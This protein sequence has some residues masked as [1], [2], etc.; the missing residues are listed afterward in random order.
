M[1]RITICPPQLRRRRP[2]PMFPRWGSLEYADLKVACPSVTVFFQHKGLR[3][4]SSLCKTSSRSQQTAIRTTLQAHSEANLVRGAPHP[5]NLS[6]GHNA[7]STVNCNNWPKRMDGRR[8]LERAEPRPSG[9]TLGQW[10]AGHASPFAQ[11]R[12]VRTV[13]GGH[14]AHQLLGLFFREKERPGLWRCEPLASS[15]RLTCPGH[16]SPA[17]TSNWGRRHPA[18]KV[19]LED[20]DKFMTEKTKLFHNGRHGSK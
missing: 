20:V 2:S 13:V 6:R 17:V 18:A 5:D 3:R 15:R 4:P 7:A 1:L 9:Q 12:Q 14:C 16:H 8:A 19:A 11:R 10:P